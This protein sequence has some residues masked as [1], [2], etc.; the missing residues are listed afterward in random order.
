[1]NDLARRLLRLIAH[2]VAL[3]GTN[4]SIMVISPAVAIC[5]SDCASR[6]WSICRPM[7]IVSTPDVS[8]HMIIG[9]R[10]ASFRPTPQTTEAMHGFR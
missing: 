6:G 3:N 5:H 8:M 2:S 1:M 10:L 4:G 7:S 9:V